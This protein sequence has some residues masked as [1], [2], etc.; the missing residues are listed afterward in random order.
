[1]RQNSPTI[2][3][4]YDVRS[5]NVNSTV[6]EQ[7]GMI[8]AICL[9]SN[10]TDEDVKKVFNRIFGTESVRCQIKDD[11]SPPLTNGAIATI[12]VLAA[13]SGLFGSIHC[14]GSLFSTKTHCWLKFYDLILFLEPSNGILVAFSVLSNGRKLF[15]INKNSNE[16]TCL[17]GIRF[18]S[19]LWVIIGHVFFMASESPVVNFIDFVEWTETLRSMAIV[20]GTMSV[21]SFL[22]LGGALLVYSYFK[23]KHQGLKFNIYQ[24]YIHRYLRLTPA[25]AAL[26]LV[27]TTL[28]PYMGTGPLWDNVTT[29][30]VKPC[31]RY[32]WTTLLY[33]QN[34]ANEDFVLCLGHSW[35]LSV[36]MQL[37]IVSPLILIPLW[38]YSKIGVGVI[39]TCIIVFIAVPF[40][41]AYVTQIPALVTNLYALDSY[42]DYTRY[43]YIK[44]HARPAPWFIGL[45]LGYLLAKVKFQNGLKTLKL[46]KVAVII[47]WA[48]CITVTLTCVFGGHSTLTGPEFDLLGNTFYIG[49]VRPTW[50]LCLAFVIF[51]CVTGNG[52]LS[53]LKKE[54]ILGPIDWFLSWPIYQVLN[55]FTYSVYLLHYPL[56]VMLAYSKK[57]GDYFDEMSAVYSFWGITMFSFGASI[58][59]VL[60]FE[61]P[62]VAIEKFIFK[63]TKKEITQLMLKD[64]IMKFFVS[65]QILQVLFLLHCADALSVE[66]EVV[67]ILQGV[68]QD[69]IVSPTC[70]EAL[71]LYIQ[72][73]QSYLD[74]WAIRMLDATSKIPVGILSG[75]LG[76]YGQYRQCLN[77]ESKNGAIKG[78]YCLGTLPYSNNVVGV[79]EDAVLQ[80]ISHI[81]KSIRSVIGLNTVQMNDNNF[82]EIL[83]L[84][85]MTRA[86][87][88]PSNCS[89]EDF[90]QV[91]NRMFGAGSVKC[92]T[93]DDL[94]P[95]LTNSAIAAIVVLAVISALLVTSTAVD[96]YFQYKNVEPPH[97]ILV[98]FSLL[99]N[100]RKLFRI[101][102]NTDELTCMNGIKCISMLWILIGHTFLMDSEA[103]LIN[104]IDFLEWTQKLRSMIIV[105]GTMSVD[106]FLMMAG[107]LLVYTYFKARHYGV[108]FNIFHFYIHRYLRLT[109]ALAALILVLTTLA[110]Y[111]GSGPL[112]ENVNIVIAKP[113][114]RYWWTSLLYLQNYVN[115]TYVLCIGHTWY[116]S[117]DMQLFFISPLILIP[118]WK[119]SKVGLGIIVTGIIA[120]IIVP[121]S[122][123]YVTEIPTL[124]NNIYARDIRVNKK[125]KCSEN[126]RLQYDFNVHSLL[127]FMLPTGCLKFKALVIT[128]WALCITVILTCVY[129]AHNTLLSPEFD[130]LGNSFYIGFVRPTWALCLAFVIFACVTGNGGV[131]NWLLSWPIY[132]VLN[133]YI[134]SMY[135]LHYP[136]M[137]MLAYS[138]KAGVYF[139]EMSSIYSFWGITMFTFCAST[140]WILT[141][142]SPIVIIEKIIFDTSPS[143]K[144]NQIE[145]S[146][147]RKDVGI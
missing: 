66:S 22:L 43:Y 121:F 25:L 103:P 88:L 90:G 79:G 14:D 106:S 108:R 143:V 55:R 124:P 27:I 85:G 128:S 38:R 130:R 35:Y 53:D 147:D 19:M 146:K 142:E 116:L 24:F 115:E 91:F 21:D 15:R 34:Y 41:I 84:T 70:Q 68:I 144:K 10:C 51:F 5:D 104:F 20:S 26:I 127:H 36:D 12:V 107:T 75:N 49:F 97:T 129:A 50:A 138:K 99:S 58:L 102:Q 61:S 32:W 60:A 140:V 89:D 40:S 83:Q 56:L 77:T 2:A 120:F 101:S 111:M 54:N 87:C 47:S 94:S 8:W 112:W 132:Q 134:Y 64:T 63:A 74:Q 4:L 105:S 125:T 31:Q 110:R 37:Y 45:L 82:T 59:W 28:A 95:S 23:A 80:R 3:S 114:E 76:D 52:V 44:T 16:L 72:N 118:L 13:F 1:L 67:Q 86:I 145:E 29:T 117:V 42:M 17:N 126:M 139:D 48:V 62:V 7:K 78:K 9:P 122:I 57:A 141:F 92:Q 33:I 98:A 18:F 46:K 30:L 100:G 93:K 69:G 135:L 109:P 39:I 133:R 96:V 119:Y 81:R 137:L 71:Q 113:C 123:A 73:L 11:L 136:I 6:S 131:I 65:L